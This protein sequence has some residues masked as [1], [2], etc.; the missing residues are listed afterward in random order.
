MNATFEV[1]VA[2]DQERENQ[3]VEVWQQ[4][5]LVAEAY[6]DNQRVCVS[7][8]VEGQFIQ[9]AIQMALDRLF[10]LH[11]EAKTAQVIHQ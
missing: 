11:P 7:C 5:K 6:F 4:D 8:F 2:S 1:L 3:T 9:E 10:A